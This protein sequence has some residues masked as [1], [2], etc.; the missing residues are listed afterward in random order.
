MRFYAAFFAFTVGAEP[1]H[2]GPSPPGRRD[3]T[4]RDVIAPHTAR[5]RYAARDVIAPYRQNPKNVLLDNHA[6][7]YVTRHSK[8]QMYSA[9]PVP[10]TIVKPL[11]PGTRKKLPAT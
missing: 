10:T 1:A 2:S 9:I 5:P 6:S 7:S 8:E 11:F 4:S 3:G